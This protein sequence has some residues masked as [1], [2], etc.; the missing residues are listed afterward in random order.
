M[1]KI[2]AA[3]ARGGLRPDLVHCA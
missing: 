3:D 2:P 1:T